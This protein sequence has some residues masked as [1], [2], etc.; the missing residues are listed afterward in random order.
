[1]GRL[2]KIAAR[3][4]MKGAGSVLEFSARP[5]YRPPAV[6]R[7]PMEAMARDFA[8]VGNDM[9]KAMDRVGREIGHVQGR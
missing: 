5:N 2:I 8:V 4:F 1:M 9:R 7:T 6:N 3:S